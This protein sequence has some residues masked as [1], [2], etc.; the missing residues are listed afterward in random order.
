[1]DATSDTGRLPTNWTRHLTPLSDGLVMLRELTV[2][3]AGSLHTHLNNPEVRRHMAP[4]PGTVEGLQRFAR[5]TQTQRRE[6]ALAC[7]AVMPIGAPDP[8]GLVQIWRVVPDF[9]TAEWGIVLGE[10]WWGRGVGRA[11]ARL[12]L[13]FAFETLNVQRLESRV[14]SANERGKRLMTR[15]GATCQGVDDNQE[16]WAMQASDRESARFVPPSRMAANG[17]LLDR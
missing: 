9:S 4:P 14:A 11:A 13:G 5:W 17:R 1:V 8:V 6:G 3:D 15:L 7:F 16:L 12:L 10:P 2:K